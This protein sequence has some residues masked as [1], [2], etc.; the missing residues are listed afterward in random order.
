MWK[1]PSSRD[2][3][4]NPRHGIALALGGG[5]ALGW[6]HIG[7]LRVLAEKKVP[8][9]AVAGTSI[10]AL[11][12]VC[13]AHDRLDALEELA[14]TTTYSR[15]LGYLDPEFGRG[16]MLGGRRIARELAFHFGDIRLENLG[17]PIAVVAADLDLA[18]EVRLTHGSAIDAVRASMALPGIF[19]PVSIDGRL[20]IDGGV[21][22]NLPVAAAR[23]LVPGLPV[24]AIDLM[25]DYAGHVGALR[26]RPRTAI[27]TVRS[28]FQIMALQQTRQTIALEH[29]AI[30]VSPQIG[31]LGSSAFTH[32]AELMQLGRE[33][34]L[35]AL[36]QIKQLIIT[37]QKTGT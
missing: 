2:P 28:A 14:S 4:L 30:V 22:A 11:A 23:A 13:L 31:H 24:V 26:G 15:V 17:L 18:E 5:A 37:A 16:A 8:I 10:G 7:A 1:A 12:A 20:L 32:A 27:A 21:L 34:T 29:P 3:Y 6:A 33:A 25:S 9:G 19:R 36:P 35:A